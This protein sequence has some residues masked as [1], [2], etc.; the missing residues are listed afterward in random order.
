MCEEFSWYLVRTKPNRERYVETQLTRIVPEVFLPLLSNSEYT[1]GPKRPPVPLFPQYVF[2]RGELSRHY[3]SIRY[4]P[5]VVSFVAN[6]LQPLSV[7]D[8]IIEGIRSRS[9]NG[10]VRI[11]QRPFRQGETVRIMGG[12]FRGFDAVFERYLSAGDRVAIL[13]NAMEGYN[14]RLVERAGNIAR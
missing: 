10:V 9:T 8:G 6:G 1:P 13:L 2:V 3:F 4:A 12:P 7:P 14:L 5:G 11:V